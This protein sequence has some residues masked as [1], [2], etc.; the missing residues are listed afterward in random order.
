MVSALPGMNNDRIP[1]RRSGG[2]GAGERKLVR[3]M[4]AP[5]LRG[6]RSQ[7]VTRRVFASRPAGGRAQGSGRSPDPARGGPSG[8]QAAPSH[9][10]AGESRGDGSL[11][12]VRR[13]WPSSRWRSTARVHPI[14]RGIG[15]GSRSDRISAGETPIGGPSE[16]T[17]SHEGKAPRPDSRWR[18]EY[19]GRGVS[20]PVPS[21][22]E[23]VPGPGSHVPVRRRPLIGRLK[24]IRPGFGRRRG[25]DRR[26]R[27]RPSSHFFIRASSLAITPLGSFL[28]SSLQ[29]SQ[30]RKKVRPSA[31]TL[32]GIPI[33]PPR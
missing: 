10:D 31:V 17:D 18:P 1:G 29:P 32:I 23:S 8:Q 24:S 3:R 30:Q 22:S 20:R 25:C 13:E 26:P 7:S 28:T 4:N 6:R 15:V 27:G 12:A 11:R 33:S 21:V 5:N 16:A 9:Q 2:V 19:T 14:A